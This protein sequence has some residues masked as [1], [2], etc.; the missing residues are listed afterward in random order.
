LLDERAHLRPTT[1]PWASTDARWRHS[2]LPRLRSS[3]TPV[4]SS[5]LGMNGKPRHS[6]VLDACPPDVRPSLRVTN[7]GSPTVITIERIAHICEHPYRQS[8][9]FF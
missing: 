5:R 9:V 2:A 4:A 3:K 8:S 7:K 1:D 6:L